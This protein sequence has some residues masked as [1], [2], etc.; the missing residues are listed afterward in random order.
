MN[1][2]YGISDFYSLITEGYFYLDRTDR[3]PQIERASNCYSCARD[4]SARA[5]CS[6]CWK[7]ITT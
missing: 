1:F 6:R 5:C 7:T 3:I 2:P 4:A